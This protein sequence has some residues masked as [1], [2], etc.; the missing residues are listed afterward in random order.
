MKGTY[1]VTV[2]NIGTVR[3]A[4]GKQEAMK[5]YNEYVSQSKDGYGRASGED[6]YIMKGEEI[7]KEY[8]GTLSLD[9]DL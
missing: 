2:G 1:S 4:V 9:N 5:V 8:T 6:V 3:K 7:Y